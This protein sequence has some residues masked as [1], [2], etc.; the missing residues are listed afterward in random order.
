MVV[1]RM[2]KTEPVPNYS[3]T[4]EGGLEMN[5]NIDLESRM[6]EWRELLRRGSFPH[7]QKVGELWGERSMIP[8]SSSMYEENLPRRQTFLAELL[9]RGISEYCFMNTFSLIFCGEDYCQ[10]SSYECIWKTAAKQ[11]V[12]FLSVTIIW[13]QRLNDLIGPVFSPPAMLA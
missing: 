6:V 11:P 7:S 1:T 12:V 9:C 2:E 5:Q 13:C 3:R 10:F 4:L 8:D